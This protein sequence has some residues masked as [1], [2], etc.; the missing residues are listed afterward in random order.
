M[1]GLTERQIRLTHNQVRQTGR[2]G[3]ILPGAFDCQLDIR[4]SGAQHQIQQFQA[5]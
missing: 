1:M 5:A 3:E 4:S 2:G